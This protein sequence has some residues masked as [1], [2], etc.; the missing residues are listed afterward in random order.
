MK[1]RNKTLKTP[2]SKSNLNSLH[3]WSL[4]SINIKRSLN[5]LR[6]KSSTTFKF[7]F[8]GDS[9]RDS[10]SKTSLCLLTNLFGRSSATSNSH[11]AKSTLQ[12]HGNKLTSG[13]KK[14]PK[15]W[16]PILSISKLRASGTLTTSLTW[17]K[18]TETSYLQQI[19]CPKNLQYSW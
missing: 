14:P 18:L 10:R 3:S 2:F 12:I 5:S 17:F 8:A 4:E 9:A 11:F 15:T 7:S 6:P 1:N 16:T 13:V 19:D